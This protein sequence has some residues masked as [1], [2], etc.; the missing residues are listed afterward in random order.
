MGADGMT[1][2]KDLEREHLEID[3]GIELFASGLG[4]GDPNVAALG[5]ALD[6]LR[7]H[8]YF[9]EERLFPPLQ[10]AGLVPPLFVMRREHGE[11][12]MTMVA[13]AAAVVPG[14][15]DTTRLRELVDRL[16]GQL[17]EHNT[18]EEMIVYP[19]AEEMIAPAILEDLAE[20]LPEVEL[21]PGWVCEAAR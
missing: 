3:Q 16:V 11:M 18:K 6:Q 17:Q 12:W 2:S 19:A 8:I 1:L 21:P 13:L 20:G 10:Q 7:R 14:A 4:P 15:S 5:A 9:E